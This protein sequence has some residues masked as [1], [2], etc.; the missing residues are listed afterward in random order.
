M[1]DSALEVDEDQ[2]VVM[3]GVTWRDYEALLAMRVEQG[4]PKLY[5]LDGML[6]IMATSKPHEGRK[7]M[8]AR[9]LEMWAA[10]LDVEISGYGDWRL[11]RKASKAGA[12]PDECY[13][14]G[15]DKRVPDLAIEIEWSLS[16]GLEKHEIY[17]RLGVRE[18]W[19]LRRDTSLV[20]R[21]LEKGRYHERKRSAVL[22]T[23]DVQWLRSFLELPTQTEAVRALRKALRT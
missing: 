20:I 6:E 23:L 2:H 17:E 3:T 1:S 14:V 16:V 21:V 10:E 19:T 11:K 13:I 8:L 7:T 12:Q 18:L 15:R 5:Y 9:L 4:R 22:P